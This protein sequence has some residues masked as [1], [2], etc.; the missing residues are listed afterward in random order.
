MLGR[1]ERK[2]RKDGGRRRGSGRSNGA[3]AGDEGVG[4]R[5][6]SVGRGSGRG[7][8]GRERDRSGGSCCKATMELI[9][10]ASRP[11]ELDEE[12]DFV[13]PNDSSSS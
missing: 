2:G 13:D 5:G 7:A 3:R 8:V 4:R 10:S 6:G 12:E 9:N 1:V 11:L